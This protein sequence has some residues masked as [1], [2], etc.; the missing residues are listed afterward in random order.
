MHECRQL[1]DLWPKHKQKSVGCSKCKRARK[2][3]QNNQ[4]ADRLAWEEATDSTNRRWLIK[5]CVPFPL[6]VSKQQ[7]QPVLIV[8]TE[9]WYG[10]DSQPLALFFPRGFKYDDKFQ[11][12]DM[13]IVMQLLHSNLHKQQQDLRCAEEREQDDGQDS[14]H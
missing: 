10:R 9:R 13:V 6:W 11:V 14:Q 12:P 8:V 5:K 2:R 1:I 4:T 7:Q 3:E